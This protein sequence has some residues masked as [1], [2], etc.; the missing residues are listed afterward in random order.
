MKNDQD[1]SKHHQGFTLIEL[2]VVVS[3]IALLI[4][5]LL[6]ALGAARRSAQH[7]QCL[8]NLK[9]VFTASFAWAAENDDYLPGPQETGIWDYRI[10]PGTVAP[11]TSKWAGLPTEENL[12]LAAVLDDEQFMPGQSNA[13]V[14][15]LNQRFA[16][17]GNTYAWNATSKFDEVRTINFKDDLTKAAYV[18][19][20]FALYE[21][22]PG[23]DDESAGAIPSDDRP[24][25]HDEQAKTPIRATYAAYLDGHAA[26]R[27]YELEANDGNGN[28]QTTPGNPSNR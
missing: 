16:D 15:P 26:P 23:R 11:P 8:S 10:A 25:V 7:A 12:G 4:A 17:N 27:K 6:P 28:S 9:Q 2:L 5:I 18:W 19:D 13:W 20:N 22:R 14:C 3:I 24:F 21:G 1:S